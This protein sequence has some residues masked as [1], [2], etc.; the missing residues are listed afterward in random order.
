MTIPAAPALGKDDQR[1]ASLQRLHSWPEAADR[2]HSALGV[3]RN[4]PRPVQVPSD[5]RELPK[6]LSCQNAELEGQSAEQH[7]RVHVREV[8]GDINRDRMPAQILLADDSNWRKRNPHRC[9]RPAPSYPVLDSP[10]FL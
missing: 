5:K 2:G 1:H 3:Y 10:V 6:R 9:L 8:V 7:W 4:L